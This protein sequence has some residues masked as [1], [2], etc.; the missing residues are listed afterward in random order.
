MN[1]AL[2]EKFTWYEKGSASAEEF[3]KVIEQSVLGFIKNPLCRKLDEGRIVMKDYHR[4]LF[5]L[6]H[7]V[8]SSSGT[9]AL[10]AANCD[11]SKSLVRDYLLKHAE[12][13]RTHWTWILND[14][15]N[16]G[17]NGEDPRSMFPIEPVQSYIAF[18]FFVAHKSPLSRLGIAAMLENLGGTFSN[19]YAIKTAEILK[20]KSEQASFFLGHGDTDVGHSKEIFK[21]LK[22]AG[23]NSQEWGWLCHSANT[24][25]QIYFRI[26][27]ASAK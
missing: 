23:L 12:E 19:K 25:A 6:F 3:E 20:L 17:Y 7:Q 4:L 13:E 10:A 8:H 5:N 18:H 21:V 15:K 24:A 9:F 1:S 2:S 27:E 16:T 22:E 11:P 14:L 26:Y